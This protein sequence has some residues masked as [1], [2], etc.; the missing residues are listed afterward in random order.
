MAVNSTTGLPYPES[1]AAYAKEWVK[2]FMTLG[3]QVRYYQIMNEPYFYFGWT[4]MTKLG[5]YVSLWNTVARSMRQENPNILISH[6]AINIK[7]VFDYWLLNG[8]NV[9]FLDYHKYD[10]D[11]I[12]QYSDSEMFQR[13]ETRGFETIGSYYGIAEARQKW[14]N[15]RGNWLRAMFSEFNFNYAWDTGTDPKI[16]QMA[17]AVWTA[18]VLRQG[19]LDGL[20]YSL[21][22]EF[23]SSKSWAEAHG[24]TGWGFG[25]V[26][27]DDD[28]PWYPYYVHKFIGSNLAVGDVLVD[29]QVSSGDVRSIAWIHNGKLIILLISKVDDQRTITIEGVNGLLDATWIDN[30]FSH[31]TPNIQTA[32]INATE[33]LLMKGYTVA[34]FQTTLGS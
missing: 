23:F 24:K 5:Y 7:K 13:A 11:T 25:M 32:T 33:P 12:N 14:Y 6:D 18:L 34:V 4:D 16:Q 29:T 26:N 31:V 17:G 15:A 30:T 3:W 2:H 19:I 10:A 8:D 9:D 20:D 21:Y 27:E 22:F 28:Q 1:Y